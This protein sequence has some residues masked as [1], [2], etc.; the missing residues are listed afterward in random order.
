M[1]PMDVKPSS[2]LSL[3]ERRRRRQRAQTQVEPAAPSRSGLNL[4]RP[5]ARTAAVVATEQGAKAASS[6][7]RASAQGLM[8]TTL[9]MAGS[10]WLMGALLADRV[11]ASFLTGGMAAAAIAFGVAWLLAPLLPPSRAFALGGLGLVGVTLGCVAAFVSQ[12]LPGGFALTVFTSLIVAGVLDLLGAGQSYGRWLRHLRFFVPGVVVVVLLYL[13]GGST[14][15]R[16]LA[17]VTPL[18]TGLGAAVAVAWMFQDHLG[19]SA[20]AHRHGQADK[21]AATLTRVC[22]IPRSLWLLL[23]DALAVDDGFSAP[24]PSSSRL[25]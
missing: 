12:V 23:S 7:Q 2:A 17:P 25:G 15:G 4:F 9:V 20:V 10:A 1:K 3:A 14:L 24:P 19:L 6:L 21:I 22:E 8:A 18:A 16:F 11:V 5:F 13:P